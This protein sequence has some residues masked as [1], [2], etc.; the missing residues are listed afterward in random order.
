M[1]VVAAVARWIEGGFFRIDGRLSGQ[2]LAALTRTAFAGSVA[3]STL[4]TGSASSLSDKTDAT[5]L[6]LQF[7]GVAYK[8]T[9][10]DTWRDLQV[11][12]DA[13]RSQTFDFFFPLAYGLFSVFVAVGVW[14]CHP[15]YR[16]GGRWVWLIALGAAAAV[17]DEIENVC[18]W[19]L[20]KGHHL[21]AWLL[22]F[23][24][25]V[26]YLKWGA[27]LVAAIIF[28]CAIA[29]VNNDTTRH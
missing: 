23:Q 20:L 8:R 19:L 29:V 1:D 26:T 27:L 28:L 7:K 25:S 12:D 15:K 6:L 22:R 9:V 2:W 4:V 14:R 13:V 5:M 24:I 18:L 16:A 10:V 11:L 17:F 3:F 21:G